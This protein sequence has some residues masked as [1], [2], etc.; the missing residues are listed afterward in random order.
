M[1]EREG[2]QR[3]RGATTAD[4]TASAPGG[5]AEERALSDALGRLRLDYRSAFLGYLS[6]RDEARLRS[7]YEIGR[8][9]IAGGVSLLDLVQVHNA[10]A[11]DLLRATS[12]DQDR[13][14]VAEAAATFLVEV[15]ATVEMTRRG[16]LET[17]RAPRPDTGGRVTDPTVPPPRRRSS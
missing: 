9:A 12:G 13:L 7:A 2:S 11:L 3:E 1:S 6:R 16:Y 15:L 8:S 14:D 5:L 10:V 4:R 17:S